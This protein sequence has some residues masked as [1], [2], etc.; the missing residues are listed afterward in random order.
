MNNERTKDKILNKTLGMK[1]Y[2]NQEP[3]ELM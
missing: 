2:I 1:E 3:Y